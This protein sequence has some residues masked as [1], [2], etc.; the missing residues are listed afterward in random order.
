[1]VA[2]RHAVRLVSSAVRGSTGGVPVLRW[3]IV[4]LGAIADYFAR[5]VR[6]HT[7]QRIVAV[8]SRSAER[9]EAFASRYSID[10]RYG[11]YEQLMNDP[12]V[13]IVYVAAPHR[14]HLPLGLQAIS[15]GKHVLIEKPNGALRR[16]G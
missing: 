3:G 4:A 13:Q 11:S 7:D 12:E 1:M 9:A 14:E 16:R 15:A 6:A 2:C 10:R 8:A 5:A